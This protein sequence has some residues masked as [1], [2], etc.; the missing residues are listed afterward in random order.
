MFFSDSLKDKVFG[1]SV[2]MVSLNSSIAVFESLT[3]RH[4]LYVFKG[5]FFVCVSKVIIFSSKL[6][7]KCFLLNAV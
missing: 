4:L 6:D 7:K 1:I 2:I 5:L 3:Y